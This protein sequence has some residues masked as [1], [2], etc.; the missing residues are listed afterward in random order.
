MWRRWWDEGDK[1]AALCSSSIS[2]TRNCIGVCILL[3][4]FLLCFSELH[5]NP[6]SVWPAETFEVWTFRCTPPCFVLVGSVCATLQFIK[7]L[8]QTPT[9]FSL[10]AILSFL[11]VL[12]SFW[13]NLGVLQGQSRSGLLSPG[14]TFISALW[15]VLHLWWIDVVCAHT[16]T[17]EDVSFAAAVCLFKLHFPVYE[18]K[19]S[20]ETMQH[21]VCDWPEADVCMIHWSSS[22]S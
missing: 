20:Y 7:G 21:G 18:L 14:S 4:L 13:F 8:R 2:H 12:F 10:C 16:P 5:W 15:T 3:C 22:N 9:A 19:N 6:D 17:A 11:K 1:T